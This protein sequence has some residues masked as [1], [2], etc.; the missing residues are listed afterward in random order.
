MASRRL[1]VGLVLMISVIAFEELAVATVLPLT[2]RELG[3][4]GLYG[5]AFSAFML[6]NVVSSVIGGRVAD[7]EGVVRPLVAGLACFTAGLIVCGTAP[8]M[9]VLVLGRAVQGLGA[10]AVVAVAFVVVGRGFAIADRPRV[11]ALLSSAWVVPSL[12]APGLGGVL[13]QH[14]GWRSVFL[15]VACTPPAAAVLILPSLRALPRPHGTAP[16][17]AHVLAAIRVAVGAGLV[18]AGLGRDTP[19]VA[20]PLVVA[21]GLV[22]FPALGALLPAGTLTARAGLP[23]AVA[24][25]ALDTFAFFGAEAFLALGLASVRHLR[26]TGIGLVLTAASVSWAV[27]SWVQARHDRRRGPRSLVTAG[28]GL[29]TVAIALGATVIAF[30]TP[31]WVAAVAWAIAGFGQGLS[32]APVNLVALAEGGPGGEGAATGAV[33]LADGLGIALG[34]GIGGAIVTLGDALGWARRDAISLVFA[35]VLAAGVL[36]MLTARRMPARVS[37]RGDATEAPREP[38]A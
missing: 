32:Y 30:D 12:I 29:V 31:V 25:R 21:G 24:T 15:L 33:Q 14:L 36:G 38:A 2:A 4:V 28:L 11:L 17:D 23:A 34:T 5:W 16:S 9:L 35:I 8:T 3:G 6:T 19:V 20:V 27:G 1:T 26:P 13:A 7:R 10:G 22:M 37:A 18:L